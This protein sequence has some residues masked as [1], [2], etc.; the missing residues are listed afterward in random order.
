MP[1]QHD[2]P[3]LARFSSVD[4]AGKPEALIAWLDTAKALPAIRTAKAALL[5][6]LRLHQASNVL[7]VGCGLGADVS[8]MARHLP[9]GGRATGI[10]ASNTMIAEARRRT[11]HLGLDITFDTGDGASLPYDD[12]GFDACRTETVLNH[13]PDPQQ[14]IREMARVTRPGGRIAALEF[15]HGSTMVDHPDRDTT[16]MILQTLDDAMAQGWI[17]RQLPR[18]FRQ[19]GLTDLQVT[20]TV[21]LTGYEI[22]Q[23]LTSNHVRRLCE[24]GIL[25]QHQ[26][27]HWWSQLAQQAAS[28][29]FLAG[30]TLILATATRPGQSD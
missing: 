29:D 7:D 11:A 1:A 3:D 19:A 13:V 28:G 14:V 23:H 8:E 10:D 17:G 24:D 2:D 30:E 4:T 26:A 6:Q 25:T 20:A 27:A 22:F 21:V 16:R 9:P 12:A 18:L 15:D 5:D